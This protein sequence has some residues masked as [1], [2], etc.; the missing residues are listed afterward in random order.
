[1]KCCEYGTRFAHFLKKFLRP[2]N[3]VVGKVVE[4]STHN[5]KSEGLNL[6][7]GTGREKNLNVNYPPRCRVQNLEQHTWHSFS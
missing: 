7:S 2:F 4:P 1:M 3:I 6:A 5:P